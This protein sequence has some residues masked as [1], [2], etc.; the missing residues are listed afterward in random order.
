MFTNVVVRTAPQPPPSRKPAPHDLDSDDTTF[1]GH[2]IPQPAPRSTRPASGS[3]SRRSSIP[4]PISTTRASFTLPSRLGPPS[5]HSLL[6]SPDIVSSSSYRRTRTPSLVPGGSSDESSSD[7]VSPPSP[8]PSRRSFNFRAPSPARFR[9][10]VPS[11]SASS[12]P[13]KNAHGLPVPSDGSPKS[14]GYGASPKKRAM[15]PENIISM[16]G[17]ASDD[18]E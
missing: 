2:A 12:S 13:E 3:T 5:A 17:V 9:D 8:S 11:E 7:G 10:L 18:G 16:P 15:G 1:F 6:P 4:V 14:P